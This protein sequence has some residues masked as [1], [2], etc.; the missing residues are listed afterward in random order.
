VSEDDKGF[1]AGALAGRMLQRLPGGRYAQEQLERLERR[2]M[3]ELKERLDR[4]DRSATVS[5]MAFSVEPPPPP[6]RKP[7][8]YAL[9]SLLRE[10]LER[11]TEQTREQARHSYFTAVLKSMLPDEARI[12]S[13]LSDSTGYALI[14]LMAGPRLG[15]ALHPVLQNFSSVGRAAGVQLAELTPVYIRRLRDWDLV[16]T[17]PEDPNLKTKYEILESE[18]EI[19]RLQETIRKG[20]RRDVMLR[21]T[22]VL[23]DLGRDL[24]EACRIS[25]D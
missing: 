7:G 13:A 20:G 15:G 6:P 3:T 24:W 21:R 9:G 5:V 14:H 19:R 1:S 11:S 16:R 23:S 12:L 4:V 2:V 8:P 17:A 25:E 18:G 22:L 10:L